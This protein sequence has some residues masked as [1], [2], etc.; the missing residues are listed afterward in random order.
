MFLSIIA[1]SLTV[2]V[3][4]KNKSDT[5]GLVKEINTVTLGMSMQPKVIDS[6][7]YLRGHVNR[8]LAEVIVYL[9]R[10]MSIVSCLYVVHLIIKFD[11]IGS[12]SSF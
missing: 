5:G 2:Q 7:W 8:K 6:R 11:E 3:K 1:K 4:A 10:D 9:I 12:F